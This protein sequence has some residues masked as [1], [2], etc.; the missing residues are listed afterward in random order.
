M[1]TD[2]LKYL[3]DDDFEATIA[4]GVSLIDFYADWCGPCRMLN[5]IIAELADEYK[6]R[7]TIAKLDVDKAQNA[8]K[9]FNVA[10]IPTVIL[11]INGEEAK[12]VVGVRDKQTFKTMLDASFA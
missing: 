1:A 4:K 11:F 3:T 2:T 5:P 8:A 10:S 6:G 12:R 9:K 7:A